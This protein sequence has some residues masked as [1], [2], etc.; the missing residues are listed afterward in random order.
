MKMPGPESGA[1]ALQPQS[2]R[3][4]SSL[5]DVYLS[6][7]KLDRADEYYEKA[8]Q[9]GGRNAHLEFN[10][11]RVEALRGRSGEALKLL[12]SALH[13]GYRDLENIRKDSALDSLRALPDFKRLMHAFL[14]EGGGE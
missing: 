2:A 5:G 6:M 9:L 3:V 7:R 11:A 10:R 14:S 13:L 1:L 8:V 12:E 4:L